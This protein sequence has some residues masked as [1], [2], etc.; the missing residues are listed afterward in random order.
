MLPIPRVGGGECCPPA[1]R[2]P[3]LVGAHCLSHSYTH[4]FCCKFLPPHISAAISLPPC[5]SETRVLL[6]NARGKSCEQPVF[7]QRLERF[8][9]TRFCW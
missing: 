9:I 4:C 7:C 3:G 1:G 2:F 5:Q 6:E 8:K